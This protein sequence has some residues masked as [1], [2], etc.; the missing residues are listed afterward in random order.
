MPTTSVEWQIIN[1][2]GSV[3]NLTAPMDTFI[4][5]DSVVTIIQFASY[6]NGCMVS[7]TTMLSQ[8]DILPT[9]DDPVL[10]YEIIPVECFSDSG[11]FQFIDM[12]V[13]PECIFIVDYVWVI[14][15]VECTGN[16][17]TKTLPLGEEI[18]FEY[19]VTLAMGSYCRQQVMGMTIMMS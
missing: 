8:D 14:N 13:V 9:L 12:S 10:D 3:I 15:G 5:R 1:L 19:T 18:T 11:I 2:D 16:P 17:V 4:M 7:D 6:P